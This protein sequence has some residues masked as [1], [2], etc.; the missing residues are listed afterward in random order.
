SVLAARD[1]SIWIGSSRGVNRWHDDALETINVPWQDGREGSVMALAE[2]A[3]GIWLG[4]DNQGL[5]R[6]P[7]DA[8]QPVLRIDRG[9]GLPSSQIR[10]LLGGSDG[11]L[12]IGTI[13]GLLRRHPDGQLEALRGQPLPEDG[14]VRSL[15]E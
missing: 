2:D 1:G 6:I 4:T 12:W 7:H 3:E 8:R 15:H 9:D 13:V 11:S 5:I 14:V 10:A